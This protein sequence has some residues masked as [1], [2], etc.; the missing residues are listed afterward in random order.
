LRAGDII[1][2]AEGGFAPRALPRTEN[3]P[4]TIHGG[5]RDLHGLG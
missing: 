1:V 4:I 2:S 5:G 3:A